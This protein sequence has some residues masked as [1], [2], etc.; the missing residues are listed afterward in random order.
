[1]NTH[2][3]QIVNGWAGGNYWLDQFMVFSADK[4]GYLLIA[5]V[6]GVF[7]IN[8]TKYQ[9]MVVVALGSAI[10]ARFGLVALIRFF[11]YHP[12]PFLVLQNIHQLM[13]HEMESSFPSGHAAFYFALANGVYLYNKKAGL[14]YLAL[15]GLMGFARVFVGVH[16][17]FD[18]LAGAVLGIVTA[19]LCNELWRKY[20]NPQL[21]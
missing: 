12:R 19:V 18:I 8:K 6:V 13:N 15:A 1:M 3:L 7:L 5:F 11:Y 17:P 9:N 20:K 21:S 4:L 14:A 2:L 16:W 10:V